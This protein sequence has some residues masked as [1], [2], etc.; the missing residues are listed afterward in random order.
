MQLL[1]TG[2][3]DKHGITTIGLAD[4]RLGQDVTGRW[5]QPAGSHRDTGTVEIDNPSDACQKLWYRQ[6]HQIFDPADEKCDANDVCQC[7]D[8]LVANLADYVANDPGSGIHGVHVYP[9]GGLRKSAKWS[10][11]VVDGHLTMNG[12]GGF[13]V[14]VELD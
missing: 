14:D 6:L 9:L 4:H 8:K 12:K 13:R 3:F 10:Y 5:Q 11:A 1:D 7:P 2:L